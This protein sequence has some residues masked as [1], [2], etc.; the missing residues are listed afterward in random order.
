MS[1]APTDLP[2][3]QPKPIF[4]DKNYVLAM[5]L[6]LGLCACAY[7]CIPGGQSGRRV[8]ALHFSDR[9]FLG[10]WSWAGVQQKPQ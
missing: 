3:G 1:I 9:L 10:T 7:L 2:P 8:N 5:F 4:G 6:I